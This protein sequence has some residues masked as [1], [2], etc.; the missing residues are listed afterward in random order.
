MLIMKEKSL[1]F[2]KVLVAVGRKPYHEGLGL[3][4]LDIKINRDNTIDVDNNFRTAVPSICY[5]RCYKWSNVSTQSKQKDI[6]F[7]KD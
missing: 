4:K 5:R 3:E 1:K 6:S 7:Q 2:E